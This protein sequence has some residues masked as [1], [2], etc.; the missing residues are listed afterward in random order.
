MTDDEI[1]NLAWESGLCDKSGL[2]SE[3]ATR[4]D[5]IAFAREVIATER[6]ACL[7]KLRLQM[8]GWRA[9]G[10]NGSPEMLAVANCIEAI[11]ARTTERGT[12]P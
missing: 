12:A 9:I 7:E 8:D 10:H 6:E 3:N 5:F 2:G 4:S 11:R 1:M